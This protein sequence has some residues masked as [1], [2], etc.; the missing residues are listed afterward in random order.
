MPC[1][2]HCSP[3]LWSHLLSLGFVGSNAPDTGGA[4]GRWRMTTIR[5]SPTGPSTCWLLLPWKQRAIVPELTTRTCRV[6][7][8]LLGGQEQFSDPCHCL[9]N[10][11]LLQRASKITALR[12]TVE[13]FKYHIHTWHAPEVTPAQGLA[14]CKG[15]PQKAQVKLSKEVGLEGPKSQEAVGIAPKVRKAGFSQWWALNQPSKS[16][17][18]RAPGSI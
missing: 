6:R 13:L 14:L 8:M 12:R 18:F 9:G 4:S 5:L 15:F 2:L 17:S 7:M 3:A 16:G 11:T 1:A 10:V